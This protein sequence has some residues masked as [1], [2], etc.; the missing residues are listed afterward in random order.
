VNIRIQFSNGTVKALTT[1]WEGA[2]RKG[3]LRLVRR[4]GAL[5]LLS[6]ALPVAEVAQLS[7]VVEQTVRNWLYAFILERFDS[8]QY[9]T[10]PGRP[11]KLSKTQKQRLKALIT[12]GPE[13]AGY[14]TGC[15]NCALIQDLILREFKVLYDVFYVSQLLHTLGLSYQKA[16]FVSD[17]LDADQRKVWI[18]HE[19]PQIVAEAKRRGALLLF[20]D[21]ASFAQWGSLARTWAPL[22]EQPLIKTCGKR[23]AYKV[24]GLIDYFCGRLFYQG[25]QG[26]FTA[27]SYCN[28]LAWVLTQTAQPLILIHDGAKYHTAKQTREFCA[29]HPERL[30]V[31]QLPAYS[32]DYNPIEHLWKNVKHDKTHNRYFP[33]FDNLIAAVEAGLTYFQQHLD[34]VKQLMGSYLDQ[35]AGLTLTAESKSFS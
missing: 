14:P 34:E 21:E 10:S 32:P 35:M 24:F 4:I 22:G 8:L 26:R 12:A 9:R 27:E 30:S 5:L 15:W 16:R 20:A 13:E 25:H 1:R 7:G 33:T 31:Y 23:K 11:A 28:F 18:D 2:F 17:H 29:E 3:D 6:K 19:W